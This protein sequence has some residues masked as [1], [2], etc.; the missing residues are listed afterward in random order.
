MNIRRLLAL[1]LLAS[2]SSHSA[3]AQDVKSDRSGGFVLGVFYF[4]QLC[5]ASIGKPDV[6]HK[7]VESSDLRKLTGEEYAK[8]KSQYGLEG[9][10][11]SEGN[12]SVTVEFTRTMSCQVSVSHAR[13]DDFRSH[14]QTLAKAEEQKGNRVALARDQSVST[15]GVPPYKILQFHVY[16]TQ[17]NFA[18]FA[19]TSSEPYQGREAMLSVG[20]FR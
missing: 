6:F 17:G 19:I 13:E 18:M 4:E 16:S 10:T 12:V 2:T 14:L 9:W 1:V 5:K 7:L 11:R 8:T 20:P 3:L 15:P